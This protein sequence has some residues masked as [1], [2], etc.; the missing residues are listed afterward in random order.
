[1]TPNAKFEVVINYEK[2]WDDQRL[3]LSQNSPPKSRLTV[4]IFLRFGFKSTFLFL[5][6]TGKN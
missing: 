3:N 2:V 6:E 1:M 4:A 5:K